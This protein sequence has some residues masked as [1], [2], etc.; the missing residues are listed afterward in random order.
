[1]KSPKFSNSFSV[2]SFDI[3][4][5]LPFHFLSGLLYYTNFRFFSIF[6]ETDVWILL[7]LETTVKFLKIK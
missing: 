6:V 7:V 2:L 3:K 4:Q 5:F 1:M